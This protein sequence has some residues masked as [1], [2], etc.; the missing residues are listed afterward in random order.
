MSELAFRRL[1]RV[2]RLQIIAHHQ[3]NFYTYYPAIVILQPRRK[4]FLLRSSRD[5]FQNGGSGNLPSQHDC[6]SQYRSCQVC[7]PH[8]PTFTLPPFCSN[9][10]TDTQFSQQILGKTRPQTQPPHQLL[11]LGHSLPSRPANAHNSSMLL[12]LLRRQSP[13]QLLPPRR[14]RRP[15]PSLF[16]RTTLSP[17]HSRVLESLPPKTLHPPFKNRLRE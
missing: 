2:D 3:N 13:P 6:A 17:L 15:N 11:R 7:A 9:H 8:S 5:S 4:Y 12:H 1:V 16:P 10:S 14:L